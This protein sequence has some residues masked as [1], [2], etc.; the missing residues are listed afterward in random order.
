[1]RCNTFKKSLEV[2]ISNWNNIC[3]EASYKRKQSIKKDNEPTDM[4][5]EVKKLFPACHYQSFI[6]IEHDS[7]HGI[8]QVQ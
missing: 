8:I 5:D 7:N 4:E 2:A 3:F 6:T 1:M